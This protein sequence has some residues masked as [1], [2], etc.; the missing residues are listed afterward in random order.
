MFGNSS[1][2]CEIV[3]ASIGSEEGSETANSKGDKPRIAATSSTA[4]SVGR[5]VPWRARI[6]AT[7]YCPAAITRNGMA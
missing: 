5:M 6:A 1:T 7:T 4:G 3:A 2:G